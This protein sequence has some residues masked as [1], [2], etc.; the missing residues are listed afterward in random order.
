MT[1]VSPKDL[2][3]ALDILSDPAVSVIAGGTDVFPAM[4]PARKKQPLMD[5]TR[6]AGL[7]E[8]TQDDGW[9]RIGAAVTWTKLVKSDLAPA[10]DALKAA[11]KEVGSI[12]IQNA[13]TLVGNLCNA[14]PAAD[15]V[16]PLLALDAEVE[17]SSAAHGTRRLALA[18]F[19]QG[20]R[21]T[22]LQPGEMVTAI[23]IPP[24]PSA[25]TSAFSKLGS[26]KYLVIS[27][28]MTAVNLT[29]RPDGRIDTARVAVGACS[30]V[31]Q[32]L[33]ALEQALV[34][35]SPQE[36]EV[37]ETHLTA[38]SPIDDVRGSGAYRLEAVAEQ[39]RRTLSG[40]AAI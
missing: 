17:I 9:T 5:V 39:I 25:M 21:Q 34:G 26:R 27:I 1:F 2:P 15:G 11:G 24:V 16:P 36:A 4:T 22:A 19:I 6:I 35:Q 30:P 12:Q 10:F 18:Q 32:R 38:L 33:P 29:L 40:A 7:G 8:I 31:A 37:S 20:V 14:S 23:L 13:G 3:A 28:C